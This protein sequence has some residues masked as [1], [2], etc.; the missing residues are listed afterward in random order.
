MSI[1]LIFLPGMMCDARLYAPQQDAFEINVLPITTGNTVQMIAQHILTKA[2]E[3]FVLGGLSM[4]GIVAMEVLRQAPERIAGLILMDTNPY[5]EVEAVR[6]AREPQKAAVRQGKLETVMQEAMLP[7]YL[8][9]PSRQDILD[10]CLD[11]AVTLGAEVFIAQSEALASRPDQCDTL[12]QLQVPT[13]ILHGDQDQ[14]CP[15]HR[16]TDME[17]LIPGARRIEIKDAG[18]L[19]TLEQPNAT[20]A[21]IQ[22]FLEEYQWR[23]PP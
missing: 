20:N 16:H 11:M 14:L 10:T 18:H 3:Q 23:S 22:A 19:P 21:A 12:R 7:K 9:D 15:P 8:A 1:P 4:G 17:A 13:L 2:P 5:A 6:Q